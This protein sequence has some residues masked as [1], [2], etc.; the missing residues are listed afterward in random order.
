MG[1]GLPGLHPSGFLLRVRH[2]PAAGGHPRGALRRQAGVRVRYAGHRSTHH[3][4][5]LH[6]LG[7]RRLVLRRATPRRAVRGEYTDN[8]DTLSWTSPPWR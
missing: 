3:R 1:R 8:L 2:R 6:R 5:P 7:R 4:Q